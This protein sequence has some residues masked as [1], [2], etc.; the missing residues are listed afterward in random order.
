MVR[1]EVVAV[2]ESENNPGRFMPTYAFERADGER[3]VCPLNYIPLETPRV[4]DQAR[5]AVAYTPP[6]G[7][8]G[9]SI[10]SVGSPADYIIVAMGFGFML[11]GGVMVIFAHKFKST[12]GGDGGN[13]GYFGGDGG[14]D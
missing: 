4:G 11:F 13:G 14:G 8:C 12:R 6:S 7:R 9:I 5:L 10:G 3:V 2:T 1:A